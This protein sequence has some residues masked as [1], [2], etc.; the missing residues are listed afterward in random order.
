V[1]ER[2]WNLELTIVITAPKIEAMSRS[3]MMRF[4]TG[5]EFD[6]DGNAIYRFPVAARPGR[7][8]GSIA[9]SIT[10]VARPSAGD[11]KAK[12]GDGHRVEL[13]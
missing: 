7:K 10:T 6:Q 13:F 3:L 4:K 1:N 2:V 9:V 8:S 11:P 12:Q 5:Q